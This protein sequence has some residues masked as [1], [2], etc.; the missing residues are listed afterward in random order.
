MDEATWLACTDLTP[1]LAFLQTSGLASARK[2][3][4]LA[5]A[6][7]R[8]A[9][10]LFS[11]KRLQAAVLASELYADGLLTAE[12]LE[13]ARSAV[14]RLAERAFRTHI[15]ALPWT[16]PV[17][18]KFARYA[19]MQ[20][21]SRDIDEVLEVV[22][23]GLVVGKTRADYEQK[24]RQ[25]QVRQSAWLRDI[26]GNPFQRTLLSSSWRTTNVTTLANAIYQ[27]HNFEDL[28]ILADAVEEAGCTDAAVLGHLRGAGPHVRGCWA[29]DLVLGKT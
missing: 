17:Q 12:E 27:E 21:A 3:R 18:N 9:G 19:A 22:G 15:R 6:C 20:V 24:L 23:S 29:L 8:G 4:L 2:L 13:N 7:C 5:V 11:L 16:I 14:A 1:M 28:P 10:R 25:K 26:F